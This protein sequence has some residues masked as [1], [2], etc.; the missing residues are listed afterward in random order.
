MKSVPIR[1][2]AIGLMAAAPF[3]PV[4]TMTGIASVVDGDGVRFGEVEIRLRGIAAPE[5][6]DRKR[7]P[8]GPESSA[9]LRA[10][11]E[12]K[13]IVC[14]LDGTTASSNRPVGIC[15]LGE[16]DIGAYQVRSGHA[17][18]CP[19]FS[20]GM[21]RDEEMEARQ[22]GKDLSKLYPLPSYC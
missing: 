21:Y 2:M 11:V 22:A 16:E 15:F 1:L 13:K 3:K 4:A 6:N 5:D 17:R 14:A 10:Y 12:G 9:N 7:E 19:A 20:N 8:G 18:D